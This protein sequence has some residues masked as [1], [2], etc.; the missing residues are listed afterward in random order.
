MDLQLVNTYSIPII[1]ERNLD[2]IVMEENVNLV[3]SPNEK[4]PLEKQIVDKIIIEGNPKE[5]NE[6]QFVDELNMPEIPRPENTIESINDIF[7]DRKKRDPLIAKSV[8]KLSL[9]RF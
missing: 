8:D 7:I 1:Q 2:D 4:K 6:I 5:D 3:I 9:I